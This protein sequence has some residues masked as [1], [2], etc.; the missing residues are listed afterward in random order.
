MTLK[1][2]KAQI[3][4]WED[5]VETTEPHNVEVRVMLVDWT[6]DMTPVEVG[7][8]RV[9]LVAGWRLVIHPDVP[10]DIRQSWDDSERDWKEK[11]GW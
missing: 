6:D 5:R 1:E 7:V 3:E 11:R 8:E 4:R 2:L 10:A 9:E